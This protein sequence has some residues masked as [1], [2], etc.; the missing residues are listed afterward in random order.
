MWRGV[1]RVA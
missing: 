1:K